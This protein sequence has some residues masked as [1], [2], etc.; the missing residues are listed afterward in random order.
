MGFGFVEYKRRADAMKALSQLQGR[1]LEGH[2]LEL[3]MTNRN[4]VKREVT[5][6]GLKC[7]SSEVLLSTRTT[8]IAVSL[9]LDSHS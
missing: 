7:S 3:T 5:Q 6:G 1:K 4:K 8:V 2:K 9:L